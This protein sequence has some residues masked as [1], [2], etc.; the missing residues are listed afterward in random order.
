MVLESII[1]PTKAERR[2]VEMLFLGMA[3]ALIGAVL[4]I[5]IFRQWSS[6]VMVFLTAMASVPLMYRTLR[7]EEHED[8]E[9]K[10]EYPLIKQH[11]KAVIFFLMLFLGFTLTFSI[12]NFAL[13]PNLE[14]VAF[15]AQR[16]TIQSINSPT[17]AAVSLDVFMRIFAN[18][19]RVLF[20]CI[21]FSFFYGAGAIFILAWNSSVIGTAI[22][23]LA[24]NK[25]GETLAKAGFVNAGHYFH[26]FTLGFL[27]YLPHGIFEVIGFFIGGLAGG[28][29]SVAVVNHDFGTKEF[30][31]IIADS[32]DLLM[33]AILI[34]FIA[35]II[36]VY[37]TPILFH[38]FAH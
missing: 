7:Y 22:G 37:I 30:N 2:P 31:H 33:L 3:Y 36:E 29:I 13:P 27:R 18:N 24:R 35:A 21:F 5:W 12:L 8:I 38:S 26:V 17:G 1:S 9:I 28:I 11:M 6:M 4:A 25:L 20:F 15:S 34:I 23:S 16:S 19:V 10:E 14:R 32:L